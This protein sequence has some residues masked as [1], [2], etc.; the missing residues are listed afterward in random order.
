MWSRTEKSERGTH[1]VRVSCD[2]CKKSPQR[3]LFDNHGGDLPAEILA[4]V[5]HQQRDAISLATLYRKTL[6]PQ[7][8]LTYLHLYGSISKRDHTPEG[9]TGVFYPG[10]PVPPPPAAAPPPQPAPNELQHTGLSSSTSSTTSSNP[11]H[12][13]AV[14]ATKPCPAAPPSSTSPP[15]ASAH[16]SA[17]AA[18]SLSFL[19]S[20]ETRG[21]TTVVTWIPSWKPVLPAS[22]RSIHSGSHRSPL[23]CTWSC[24]KWVALPP[25]FELQQQAREL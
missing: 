20:S 10:P 23:T 5:T 25:N 18:L 17:S 9:I 6:R 7:G 16:F 12:R 19:I 3:F 24:S 8:K 1:P 11:P 21:Q 15:L 13:A 2:S 14:F 22:G 4:L